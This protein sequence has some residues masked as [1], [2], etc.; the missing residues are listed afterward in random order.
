MGRLELGGR[1]ENGRIRW[2]A[3]RDMVLWEETTA[4]YEGY[5]RGKI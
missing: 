5:L 4:R 1:D 2:E 3:G